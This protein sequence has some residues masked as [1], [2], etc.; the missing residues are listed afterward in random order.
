MARFYILL[1]AALLYGTS[2]GSEPRREET[3]MRVLASGWLTLAIG[4]VALASGVLA[5]RTSANPADHPAG[6]RGRIA[7]RRR[8]RPPPPSARGPPR[9]PPRVARRPSR[10]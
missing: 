6:R 5:L 4:A 8:R 3:P 9:H 10:R 7:T 1:P 2:R